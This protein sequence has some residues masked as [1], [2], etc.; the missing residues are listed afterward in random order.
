MI[1]IK[2]HI[3][4]NDYEQIVNKDTSFNSIKQQNAVLISNIPSTTQAD[5]SS[6]S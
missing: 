4:N 1:R 5:S 6:Q 2:A 3:Q